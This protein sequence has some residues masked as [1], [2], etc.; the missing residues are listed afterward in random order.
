MS[1]R[2]RQI[3][4]FHA[5]SVEVDDRSR[6]CT[7]GRPYPQHTV[8]IYVGVVFFSRLL[9]LILSK[10]SRKQLANEATVM[11]MNDL[12]LNR[13]NGATLG[14]SVNK[15][16]K[17]QQNSN[18]LQD[19][20]NDYD[21][22]N[23]NN[24]AVGDSSRSQVSSSKPT[25]QGKRKHTD[26]EVLKVRHSIQ[27]CCKTNDLQS[28]LS[29]FNEALSSGAVIE[30]QTYY[31]LLAL[32]DGFDD[33]GLHIG[34]PRPTSWSPKQSINK[35]NQDGKALQEENTNVT[36]KEDNNA[37]QEDTVE[38]TSDERKTYAFGI[39]QKM[40]EHKIPFTETAYTALVR[41][42]CKAKETTRAEEILTEAESNPSIKPRL[43][44]YSALIQ[45][46]SEQRQ[47]NKVISTWKRMLERDI[48]P[49]EREYCLILQ[50][51]VHV[52]DAKV[53]D[54]VLA[55][56]AE[57]V[58]VPSRATTQA[59]VN[60]FSSSVSASESAA[61]MPSSLVT[62]SLGGTTAPSIGPVVSSTGRGW[63]V[64]HG[65]RVDTATGALL[66]GCLAQCYLKPVEL[67]S[68]DRMEMMHMNETIVVNDGLPTDPSIYGGGG[69]GPKRKSTDKNKRIQSWE[70]FKRWLE[71]Q[72]GSG[73]LNCNSS[74]ARPY[75]VVIDGANVGYFKQN[76]VNAPKHV[77]YNQIDWVVRHF[78][79][80]QKRVLLVLH[81]RHFS[82]KLMPKWA[83]P[84]VRRWESD[85]ILF[86]APAGCN[87]DWFWLHAA[88]W[89]GRECMVVTN[90]EMRD[91]H[92][93]MLAYRSFLRW[94]ERHQIRF[95]FGEWEER[96]KGDSRRKLETVYPDVYSRRIQRVKRGIIIPLPKKGD[97]KRF[98]DGDF[99]SENDPDEET[100]V[101]IAEVA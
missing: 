4:R 78:L 76:Y 43:R 75:D 45:A 41:V 39:K 36:E 73:P 87:D 65:C 60:W 2:G 97:E 15:K 24:I 64:N 72:V 68:A 19:E 37:R 32:C 25:K 1:C 53:M 21:S 74:S 7:F 20:K 100:Y 51:A 83:Q 46:L 92:F 63:T 47:M 22:S 58:L 28:A 86:R 23:T 94:K 93:Q 54:R 96:G 69:K 80:N 66:D 56:L 101:C 8:H 18:H 5:S 62:I 59:V 9:L 34:T 98:L 44:M 48:V 71:R 40:D 30:P 14:E 26:A 55:D 6:R 27:M 99:V 10:S 81:E 13:P 85:D 11:R 95:N 3:K 52:G 50:C 33:R 17:V 89:C 67:S 70:S 88:L 38:I 35:E 49:S 77:D 90:D 57:D 61:S 91:H 82:P 16:Q 12:E 84:I 42:L 29:L 31:C 79:E